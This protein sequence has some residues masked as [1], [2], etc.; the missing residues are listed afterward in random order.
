MASSLQVLLVLVLTA[1]GLATAQILSYP[2]IPVWNSKAAEGLLIGHW[3]HL[4]HGVFSG[5]TRLTSL[6]TVEIRDFHYDGSGPNGWFILQ[7]KSGDI[8]PLFKPGPWLAN[9]PSIQ[10]I[11]DET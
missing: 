7:D 2:R 5:E 8:Q 6:R 3:T 1:A 11:P 10:V 9:A 4:A